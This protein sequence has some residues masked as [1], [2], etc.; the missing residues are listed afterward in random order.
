MKSC[1]ICT[2]GGLFFRREVVL[3][4]KVLVSLLSE[5]QD[6]Q[7]MQAADARETGRRLG[8]DVEDHWIIDGKRAVRQKLQ[9]PADGC[10]INVIS[11]FISDN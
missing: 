9:R 1:W 5:E 11:D 8:L 6:F 3:S 4:K 2:T 10:I 7:V